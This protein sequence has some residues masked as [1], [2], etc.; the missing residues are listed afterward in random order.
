MTDFHQTYVNDTLWDR[1]ECFKFWGSEVQGHN[2]GN[3]ALRAA[4]YSSRRFAVEL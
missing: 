4:A 3:S 2:A 1:D